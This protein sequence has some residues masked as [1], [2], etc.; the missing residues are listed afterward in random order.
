VGALPG[1]LPFS[2]A[3]VV[4]LGVL[5]AL[6][7]WLLVRF[8]RE[9]RASGPRRAAR[10]ASLQVLAGLGF[11]LL[12]FDLAW[13]MQYARP[14]LAR[15][16]GWATPGAEQATVAEI[17]ALAGGFVAATNDAYR[18]RHG[19]D[20]AGQP[21]A[22]S[23]LRRLEGDLE[24]GFV[25]ASRAGLGRPPAQPLRLK[26]LL[27]SPLLSHLGLAGFY[28]PWTAEPNLNAMVPGSHLP[29]ASAHEM[30]H[31]LGFA[32]E[33]EAQLGGYLACVLS[34]SPDARYSGLLYAQ[35]ALLRQLLAHDQA[36]AQALVRRRLPGVQR[37]VDHVVA[38]WQGY[39]GP[40]A[41]AADAVND[42]YLRAQRVPGGIRSYG[43]GVRLLLLCSRAGQ[44]ACRPDTDRRA[45]D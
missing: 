7:A 32:R 2:V 24:L 25:A 11:V 6:A 1:L 16:H 9:W 41:R 21:T 44:P 26:P 14:G 5:P 37:D 45:T 42:A 15:R 13:G 28:F 40:P 29:H 30:A 23:D 19:A 10:E 35:R 43:E 34:P 20:D 18:R 3:E 31:A 8:H 33:D 12:S 36:A 38:F 27:A 22:R 17:E 39:E 4:L